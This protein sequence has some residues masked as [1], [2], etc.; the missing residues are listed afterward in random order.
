MGTPG[1]TAGGLGNT[2]VFGS[3]EFERKENS[4]I[5]P[6]V[7]PPTL[8]SN[9]SP[10]Q[11]TVGSGTR[12]VPALQPQVPIPS[13]A[14][15]SDVLPN[16]NEAPP[17][18]AELLQAAPGAVWV[19]S[20]PRPGRIPADSFT[21]D[22]S[23]PRWRSR[24][25]YA[26]IVDWRSTR[27]ISDDKIAVSF[28]SVCNAARSMNGLDHQSDPLPWSRDGLTPSREAAAS[29]RYNLD[30][31][32]PERPSSSSGE[33]E[34][35]RDLL[36][37]SEGEQAQLSPGPSGPFMKPP[38]LILIFDTDRYA[39]YVGH[40]PLRPSM[41]STPT[42]SSSTPM[43]QVGEKPL[44]RKVSPVKHAGEDPGLPNTRA[45]RQVSPPR[46]VTGQAPRVRKP[47]RSAPQSQPTASLPA[48]GPV[49]TVAPASRLNAGHINPTVQ[50]RPFG[51]LLSTAPGLQQ[52][53]P[54]QNPSADRAILGTRDMNRNV[55]NTPDV[56]LALVP[57]GQV[58]HSVLSNTPVVVT[59]GQQGPRHAVET[60]PGNSDLT[61]DSARSG[62]TS[63]VASSMLLDQDAAPS[64][65]PFTSENVWQ[66]A[67]K[68]PVVSNNK[69]PTPGRMRW[70]PPGNV[71]LFWLLHLAHFRPFA[72]HKEQNDRFH[73]C[74]EYIKVIK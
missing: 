47:P 61:T 71:D 62:M 11:V 22:T 27:V 19:P 50:Y 54:L 58:S 13:S 26:D 38:K 49:P 32:R 14:G 15:H 51:R 36:V 7:G 25:D 5:L 21:H 48:Q 28:N 12:H 64:T 65:W 9:R 24:E 10:A 46:P 74:T 67:P 20:G 59:Q 16:A 70:G 29:A 34:V 45:R 2:V 52:L 44:V 42:P 3:L 60:R 35:M 56:A 63:T 41:L 30:V 73:R 40:G 23:H 53:T 72:V 55:H 31:L 57:P 43:G 18:Q 37:D 1:G 17:S 6:R 66:V 39:G 8:A 33:D 68:S 69:V 4:P